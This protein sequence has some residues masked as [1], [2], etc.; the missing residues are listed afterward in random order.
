MVFDFS[1]VHSK[2]GSG[3]SD[4]KMHCS[5]LGALVFY[6]SSHFTSK[7][8]STHVIQNQKRDGPLSEHLISKMH[9]KIQLLSTAIKLLNHGAESKHSLCLLA[10]LNKQVINSTFIN[11]SISNRDGSRKRR[12]TFNGPEHD[13]IAKII[14]PVFFF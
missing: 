10:K 6:F 1:C 4:S 7:D 12:R 11:K 8:M 5:V 2:F 14:F 3:K 13:K 9:N